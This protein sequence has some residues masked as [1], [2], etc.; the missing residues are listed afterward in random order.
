M[1]ECWRETSIKHIIKHDTNIPSTLLHIN[2]LQQ[3]QHFNKHTALYK[4]FNRG[5]ATGSRVR[6]WWSDVWG[7]VPNTGPTAGIWE[8]CSR[9]FSKYDVHI[10]SFWCILTA[11]KSLAQAGNKVCSTGRQLFIVFVQMAIEARF[12]P[13]LASPMWS[14]NDLFCSGSCTFLF[15]CHHY[16]KSWTNSKCCLKCCINGRVSMTVLF[17]ECWVRQNVL[18]YRTTENLQRN[19]QYC[20]NNWYVVTDA[21]IIVQRF[22]QIFHGHVKV[23]LSVGFP[24][25]KQLDVM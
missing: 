14:S 2:T 18:L 17:T 5:E 19:T 6:W 20:T 3:L 21:C 10:C 7:G 13:P 22:R 15:C 11:I 16:Y 4:R 8:L 1:C 12:N 25:E 9:K 23:A 24:S